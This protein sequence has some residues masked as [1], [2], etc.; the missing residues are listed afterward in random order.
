MKR[1]LC[2]LLCLLMGMTVLLAGC[3]ESEES[4]A[5]VISGEESTDPKEDKKIVDLLEGITDR[6][7]V[8]T[9]TPL[10]Y[11]PLMTDLAVKLAQQAQA[12][13]ENDNMLI[14]PLSVLYAMAMVSNGADNKEAVKEF[15]GGAEMLR[16]NEFLN[17]YTAGLTQTEKSKL[18]IANSV[19]FTDKEHFTVNRDF[20][21]TVA[22]YYETSAF[23][24]PFDQQTCKDINTWVEQS[25]DGMIKNILDRI[26]EDAV[27]YLVNTLA[28]E[29]EWAQKF[30]ENQ[31][32]EGVFYAAN[33]SEQKV[34]MMHGEDAYL[35]DALAVGFCK[36]YH[37]DYSFVAMLPKEGV[38][39]EE[40]LASLTGVTLHTLLNS[41]GNGRAI[42]VMPQFETE[43]D[44]DMR[45]TLKAIGY[46][47]D[48]S[49]NGVG[50]S[51]QGSIGI[52]RVLHKTYITVGP[53]GTK[54][55][56]ATVVEMLASG[57]PEYVGTVEL[58]RPFVYM[59]VD[60]ESKI[61]LF[62]GTVKKI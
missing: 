56:A 46:P 37:G 59:I 44:M 4:S 14:S 21:Q 32:K 41:G 27:M 23:A 57:M 29:A 26:P 55:G 15:W 49:F 1:T 45:E 34:Q 47:I 54:A 43:F 8:H 31:V 28:F 6:E 10:D 19:W 17:E 51:T 9:I 58:N 36:Y 48:G 22:D 40:Y 25:T 30:M 38:S 61:P 16:I 11:S 20:L 42:T 39:V 53:Q 35:E 12:K 62:I 13:A 50:T 60:N 52:S 33:G 18:Q 5:P 3:A 24:A 2:I 7:P